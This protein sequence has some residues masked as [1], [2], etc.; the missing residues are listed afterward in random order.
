MSG[1]TTV[2]SLSRT[3]DKWI[4]R[5]RFTKFNQKRLSPWSIINIFNLIHLF[6]KMI[7]IPDFKTNSQFPHQRYMTIQHEKFTKLK[8]TA[9]VK[10]EYRTLNYTV[11]I[12]VTRHG[13]LIKSAAVCYIFYSLKYFIIFVRI[14]DLWLRRYWARDRRIRSFIS[15]EAFGGENCL[16]SSNNLAPL[17]ID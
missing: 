9:Y 15:C 1:N 14:T 2:F 6:F 7:A 4:S 10:Y 5:L 3:L 8:V 12:N 16:S 11:V 13:Q 17:Y